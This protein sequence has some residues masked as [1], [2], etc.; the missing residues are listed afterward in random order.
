[1]YWE[2]E[3]KTVTLSTGEWYVPDF[4][5]PFVQA[6]VEVKGDH[7][8]RTDKLE[9][10]AADLWRASGATDAITDR[11]AP[12]ILKLTS[13]NQEPF[14]RDW[15]PSPMNC[16]GIGKYGSAVFT[17]CKACK[18]TTVVALWQ[19]WCRNCG[20]EQSHDP[21]QRCGDWMDGEFKLLDIPFEWITR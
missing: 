2:Y 19:H 8:E 15:H 10:F 7:K 21:D 14:I 1:L 16:L 4:K 9:Q 20:A 17:I 3:P 6:W 11:R 12:M 5:L 18:S 13:P